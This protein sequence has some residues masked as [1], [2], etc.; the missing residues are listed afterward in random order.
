[1]HGIT[2]TQDSRTCVRGKWAL[3]KCEN[4][5]IGSPLRGPRDIGTLVAEPQ[6]RAL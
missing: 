3:V 5:A 4:P 6:A 1:M 2:T